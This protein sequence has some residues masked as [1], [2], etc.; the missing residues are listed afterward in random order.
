[1]SNYKHTWNPKWEKNDENLYK[2]SIGNAV[3]KM[4]IKIGDVAQWS[5]VYL[6][7]MWERH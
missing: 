4:K 7:G 5:C 2:E 3:Y 1:M 6:A